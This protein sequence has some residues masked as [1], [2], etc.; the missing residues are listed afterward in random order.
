MAGAPDN[1]RGRGGEPEPQASC[2]GRSCCTTTSSLWSTI[3]VTRCSSASSRTLTRLRLRSAV[4]RRHRPV[5]SRP[6]QHPRRRRTRTRRRGVIP[7]RAGNVVSRVAV[8]LDVVPPGPRRLRSRRG[9]GGRAL[10]EPRRPRRTPQGCST[11]HRRF[12]GDCFLDGSSNLH[13]GSRSFLDG[14]SNLDLGG[15]SFLEQQPDLGSRVSLGVSDR[16][17]LSLRSPAL[18]WRP[19]WP[20]RGTCARSSLR[21]PR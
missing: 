20:R 16:R 8:A 4:W 21:R 18:G 12:D 17:S 11:T 9:A 10:R 6:S 2:R 7:L 15:R 1:A 19:W 14:S 5:R 3:P 13:L